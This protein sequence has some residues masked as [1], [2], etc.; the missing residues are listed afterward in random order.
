MEIDLP[1]NPL[2]YSAFP[3]VD[4]KTGYWA[5]AGVNSENVAMTA[6]ETITSNPR[7]L[8][9]DPLLECDYAGNK[10]KKAGG[11]GEEDIVVIT[12]PYIHS[13]REGVLRLGK[14]IED[15]GTYESNGIAFSDQNEIWWLESIGGHHWIARKVDDDSYVTM[16]N[17]FGLDQFSFE[18]AYGEKKENLCSPDLLDFVKTNNLDLSPDKPFNPRTAFGSHS[19]TDHI[20]NTPRAWY[21]ERYLS[22]DKAK[23]DGENADYTPLSDDIP[24]SNTPDKKIT[25]EDIKYLLSSHYQGTVYDPYAIYGDHS[26]N[27]AYRPIGICRTSFLS[28]AEIRPTKDKENSALIHFAFGCNIFN[29]FVPFYPNVTSVPAYFS[30]TTAVTDSNNF[31]WASRLIG[32]MADSHFNLTSQAIERYQNKVQE[33]G[34]RIIIETDK[35]IERD[36]SPLTLEL[37]NSEIAKM[38]K[39]ET[40]SALGKVLYAVSCLMKCGYAKSD[41]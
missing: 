26:S 3:N 23:W 2:R 30:K 14:L 40:D 31:Y 8:G 39:Q 4:H 7:V 6:T 28:L 34:N 13:A 37:A 27:G 29:A 32:A 36:H 25:V 9:A 33:E 15:Q 22:K 1:D 20:Y 10:G 16:P 17:Q 21:I 38:V 12:L 5:A 19:D 24:W 41:K 35:L 11:L 18:D